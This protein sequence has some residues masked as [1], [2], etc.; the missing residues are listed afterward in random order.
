MLRCRE[1]R[2]DQPGRP[3]DEALH[4]IGPRRHLAELV[5]DGAEARD[6]LAELLALRP[7]TRRTSPIAARQP[8]THM[9]PSLNRPKFSVLSATL[10]PLP[11]S[12]E[13]VAGGHPRI[14]QHDRRRRRAVQAHLVLFLAGAHAR[15]GLLD[16]ERGEVLA[17]DLRKDDD[18]V[19]EAA[20]GDPHL[21]AVERPGSVGS[22]G[23]ARLGRE[24]VGPR[25]R[26]R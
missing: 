13:H 15:K 24:R 18:H 25:A 17:V 4:R 6:W 2:I 19:G 5:L 10:W 23:R 20:V 22:R 9:P 1:R 11:I 3:V 12:P 8:P 14:L 21:L 7:R 26:P 16:D